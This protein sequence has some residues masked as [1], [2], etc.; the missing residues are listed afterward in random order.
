MNDR[1]IRARVRGAVPFLLG[2]LASAGT[3]AQ[4]QV[5]GGRSYLE[6]RVAAGKCVSPAGTLLARDGPDK[7]WQALTAG[8]A[9]STRDVLLA[10]PGIRAEVEPQPNSVLLSLRGNLPE[11][12]S[13][14]GLE[15]AVVLHDS[16][17]YDLDFTLERGRVVLT[18]KKAKGPARVWVRVPAGGWQLTLTEPGTEVAL[19]INGR[20]PRGTSF[21]R[22][23]GPGEQ[24]AF[25]LTVL[26]I[27]GQAN[28]K[29]G[30]EEHGMSAVSSYYWDSTFGADEAP[31]R[32]DKLPDWV[33]NGETSAEAK[34]VREVATQYLA[35]VKDK[36]PDAALA[37]LLAGAD[38]DSDK[39]RAAL[40]REFAV[41]GFGA[42]DDLGRV[43][44]ALADPQHAD[45]REAAVMALRHWIGAAA[46]NDLILY[47]FLIQRLRFPRGQ[48]ETVLQLLHSPFAPEQTETYETLVTYLGHNRLAIRE[49]AR[50]HLYRLAPNAGKSISFD[51]AAPEAERAKAREGWRKL[52]RN[53]D[54]PEREKKDG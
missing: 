8:D 16:R 38:R 52:L 35:L 51:A 21:N 19:E 18:N 27:K 4:A 33:A 23:A 53:G 50:W 5:P 42:R 2:L 40:A 31:Q 26:V 20:W 46:G 44:E 11:L 32:R 37:G 3:L 28:L 7:E 6:P 36:G 29:T 13:F 54:L 39:A 49:L 15:S 17:A 1:C 30:A 14:A 24:P 10:L 41:L 9:V 25:F 12:S 48:A 47:R 22:E 43:A 45:V 34:R